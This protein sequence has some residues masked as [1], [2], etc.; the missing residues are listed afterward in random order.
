[1]QAVA[2]SQATCDRIITF[3]IKYNFLSLN[4]F[5]FYRLHSLKLAA[6]NRSANQK[7]LTVT[8]K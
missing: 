3:T 4:R 7:L 2:R 6:E 1:M 5:Y 8:E